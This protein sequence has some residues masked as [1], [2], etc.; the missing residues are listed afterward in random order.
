MEVEEEEEK[1]EEEEEE[2]G[3]ENKEN[4]PP[5]K[6][7][8]VYELTPKRSRKAMS[9]RLI[10]VIKLIRAYVENDTYDAQI[11][12]PFLAGQVAELGRQMLRR[13]KESRSGEH[14]RLAAL[15]LI[16]EEEDGDDYYRPC[17][18]YTSPSPRD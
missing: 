15:R 9:H 3:G 10:A 8:R 2:E 4:T 11:Q 18:L 17:L 13:P 5:R 16:Q 1:E 6:K 12:D 14:L 7:Q